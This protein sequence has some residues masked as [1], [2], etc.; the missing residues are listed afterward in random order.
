VYNGSTISIYIDGELQ[1]TNN[2]SSNLFQGTLFRLGNFS[3]GNYANINLYSSLVYNKALSA[4]EVLQ[5][6]QATK[7]KFLGSNI[8]TNGLVMYLDAADKDSYSGTGTS[9]DDL[10]G[11]ENNGTLTNGPSFLPSVNGGVFSFDGVDDYVLVTGNSTLQPTSITLEAFFQRDGGRT[12]ISYSPDANGAAKTY[13]FEQA[14]NSSTFQAKVVTSNNGSVTLNGPILA[15]STWYHAV[16]TY[17]GST[18]TLYINGSLYTSTSATGNI[19]YVSNS[20]LNIGRK[21]SGDGEYISGKFPIARVYNRALS[22]TEV[23]QNY[24]AQKQR[25]GL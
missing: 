6:Y 13:S 9:W 12:I 24:N 22:A 11:N 7:D 4:G 19:S 15:T 5:N 21:N 8:V 2:F 10:S 1:N 23:A 18:V 3:A 25:F 17:N 14:T 20:N 16:M